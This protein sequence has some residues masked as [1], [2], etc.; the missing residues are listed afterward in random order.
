MD[1][2]L[3]ALDDPERI[4]ST[5]S[6]AARE[7]STAPRSPE[8]APSARTA[9]PAEGA[10]ASQ[11]ADQSA[12]RLSAELEAETLE[13]PPVSG[14]ASTPTPTSAPTPSVEML[15]FAPPSPGS[16]DSIA[17]RAAR[18]EANTA[19]AAGYREA[20]RQRIHQ[21]FGSKADTMSAQSTLDAVRQERAKIAENLTTLAVSRAPSPIQVGAY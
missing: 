7:S 17:Y 11:S 2:S 20:M 10:I 4:T 14:I 13:N 8:I 9:V 6:E 19:L 12:D 1:K 5:I 21:L 16:A 15:A 3:I 18:S